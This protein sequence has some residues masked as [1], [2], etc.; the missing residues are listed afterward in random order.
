M[1]II[2]DRENNRYVGCSCPHNSALGPR[3]GKRGLGSGRATGAGQ[4]PRMFGISA[5]GI[6]GRNGVHL[7]FVVLDGPLRTRTGMPSRSRTLRSACTVAVPGLLSRPA[8]MSC[9][10]MLFLACVSC[11][12]HHCCP[13]GLDIMPPPL[14]L[15]LSVSAASRRPWTLPQRTMCSLA[16]FAVT[17]PGRTTRA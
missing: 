10:L 4:G 5:T 13:S 2:N 8:R 1:S 11:I 15:L 7:F 12:P 16:V 14:L 3:H 9:A 6:P 17:F